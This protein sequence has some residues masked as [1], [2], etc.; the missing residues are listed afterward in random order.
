M[1]TKIHFTR[2]RSKGEPSFYD[3]QTDIRKIVPATM[4][5]AASI[6]ESKY[7]E[8]TS[9]FDV[10]THIR[11]CIAIFQLRSVEDKTHTTDQLIEFIEAI[12]K[13]N[14]KVVLEWIVYTNILMMSSYYLF[15]RRDAALDSEEYKDII[16]Y[17]AFSLIATALTKEERENIE[18]KI[19]SNTGSFRTIKN[20]INEGGIIVK[21]DM[22]VLTRN[23][24][25]FAKLLISCSGDTDWNSLARACEQELENNEHSKEEEAVLALAYPRYE[26]P[27][28]SVEVD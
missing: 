13:T 8:G 2:V 16:D 3:P 5:I 22:S 23:A 24:Q 19:K 12:S 10:A 9:E 21:D 6:I 26:D 15:C 28:L 18:N 25:A 7:P 1:T 14:S 17:S 11:K 4:K 27:G 20:I